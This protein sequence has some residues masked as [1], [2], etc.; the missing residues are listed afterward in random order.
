M[1]GNL[2]AVIHF[3]AECLHLGQRSKTE[4]AD[5]QRRVSVVLVN[6]QKVLIEPHHH[7]RHQHRHHYHHHHSWR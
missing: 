5:V 6:E 7:L 4:E 2:A 3:D 1:S